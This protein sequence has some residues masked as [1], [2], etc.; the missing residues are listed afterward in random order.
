MPARS[1]ASSRSRSP[2]IDP[3][4]QSPASATP[5]GRSHEPAAPVVPNACI[6]YPDRCRWAFPGRESSTE[7]SLPPVLAGRAYSMPMAIGT[8][9]F[10]CWCS[11]RIM[12][13]ACSVSTRSSAWIPRRL[14]GRSVTS[15]TTC[16]M[17]FKAATAHSPF[18]STSM[19]S[20]PLLAIRGKILRSIGCRPIC[21]ISCVERSIEGDGSSYALARARWCPSGSPLFRL[22]NRATRPRASRAMPW[23]PTFVRLLGG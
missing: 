13:R 21:S 17:T 18:S 10:G 12:R 6:G 1:S 19:P 23:H 15:S 16:S 7:S 20:L 8:I 3:S 22:K 14:G 4:G 5:D 2:A 11:W 9:P